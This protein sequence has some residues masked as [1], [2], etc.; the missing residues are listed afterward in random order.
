M[1][2]EKNLKDIFVNIFNLPKNKINEKTNYK[3]VKKWDSLNQVKLIMAIESKFKILID[4]DDF[5]TLLSYSS[6]K[7]Y[8]K[9]KYK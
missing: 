2:I 3:N 5:I 9:K 1:E 8:L 7:D 6:I 4:P